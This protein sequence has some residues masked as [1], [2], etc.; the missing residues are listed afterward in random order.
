MSLDH[1]EG[2]NSREVGF[3]AS[4]SEHGDWIVETFVLYMN[5]ILASIR[6]YMGRL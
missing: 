2:V 5:M 1:V 3:K 6:K 4:N